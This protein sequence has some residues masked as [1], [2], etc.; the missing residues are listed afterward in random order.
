MCFE[1]SLERLEE[2]LEEYPLYAEMLHH[3]IKEVMILGVISYTLFMLNQFHVFDLSN[4]NHL[5]WIVGFEFSHI[6]LFWMALVFIFKSFLIIQVCSFSSRQ[7]S[8]LQCETFEQTLE[9]FAPRVGSPSAGGSDR[10][11][12]EIADLGGTAIGCRGCLRRI[13]GNCVRVNA[14]IGSPAKQ[15]IIWQL[16]AMEFCKRVKMTHTDFDFARYMRYT[17]FTVLFA[18]VLG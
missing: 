1:I 15:D 3:V 18:F 4:D 14:S 5:T 8:R 10:A 11:K 7:W 6:L 12:R 9:R 2:S 16:M 17:H 13:R